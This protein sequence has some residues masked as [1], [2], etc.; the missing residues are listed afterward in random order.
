[1]LK[2]I[3][4]VDGRYAL[5][6]ESLSEYFSEYALIRERCLVEIEYFIALSK[7]GLENF[8]PLSST[9]IESL[10][11]I[12]SNFSLKYAE[13]VKEIESTINHDVKA[14]EYF[15][16]EKLSDLQLDSLGEWVHFGLTS[17]DIN[18]TAFPGLIRKSISDIMT[19]VLASLLGR[20]AS[21]AET[22][23]EVPMLART[24]G[25]PASPT[26]VGK[27]I[28]VFVERLSNQL[29]TLKNYEY[30]AKFGG[31]TGNL[32]AHKTSLPQINWIEFANTFTKSLRL[33]RFQYTTQIAHY[34]DLAELFHIFCRI[35]TILLDLCKD[36]WT[37]ISMDYFHQKVNPEEV[38]SSAMPH[39]VNP[40]D[41]ENGEGN[42]G[43]AN[44][45]FLHLAQKL[46]VSRLQRDL[47]DSTVLRNAG[48]PYAHS[49]I[50][51][52]SIIK[53]LGKITLNEKTIQDDLEKQWS[54]VAEA[55]QT[56]LRREGIPNPYEL[57]KSL[58]RG[59]KDIHQEDIHEFIDNLPVNKRL[60]D[61]LKAVTPYNYLGYY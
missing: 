53:G 55:I 40:I 54:V 46:P 50:A 38:G 25:Q 34:D 39:K 14:I 4:P 13:R 51:Y 3:S 52:Q 22:Y 29:E 19:P 5:K 59:K 23:R 8:R 37:Y 42:L 18:N 11:N 32:N 48:I 47:T 56:I 24:H 26:T 35:N 60:K 28:R 45:A 15:I 49:L 12:Y 44:A 7:L 2:A 33:S 43:V 17:Q 57:L 41:F 10:R 20:L 31:A 1:M 21:M 61:E 16:K 36:M 27:E 9:E 6:T 30:R 58:T